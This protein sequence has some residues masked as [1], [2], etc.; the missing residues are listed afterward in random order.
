M[1]LKSPYPDMPPIPEANAHYMYFKRPDQA[2]WPDFTSLIDAQTGERRKHSELVKR[3][4][5]LATALGMPV[6]QGGLGLR[7]EDGEL[8]GIFSEN[9]LV[10]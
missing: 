5:N 1:Y 10:R 2:E 8:V 6:S 9:C 7:A 3:I 4:E